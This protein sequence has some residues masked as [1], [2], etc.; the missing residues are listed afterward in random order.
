M[1]QPSTPV[2]PCA[3]SCTVSNSSCSRPGQLLH[4]LQYFASTAAHA[5]RPV[6]CRPEVSLHPYHP[7]QR[8][9]PGH[10]SRQIRCPITASQPPYQSSLC[11]S[12]AR[13]VVTPDCLSSLHLPLPWPTHW[14]SMTTAPRSASNASHRQSIT[15]VTRPISILANR[16]GICRR[17][18]NSYININTSTSR[19]PPCLNHLSVTRQSMLLPH[20]RQQA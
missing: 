4:C 1:K 6:W 7:S 16:R 20:L 5:G 8:P 18:R 3:P 2:P 12:L 19:R 15:T 10:T 17:C 14:T 11:P 9:K 13:C